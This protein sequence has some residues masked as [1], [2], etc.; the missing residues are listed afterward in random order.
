MPFVHYLSFDDVRSQ[1]RVTIDPALDQ[2]L[3]CMDVFDPEHVQM[4]TLGERPPDPNGELPFG[5]RGCVIGK[6][7]ESD[8]FTLDIFDPEQNTE[9]SLIDEDRIGTESALRERGQATQVPGSALVAPNWAKE[10]VRQFF[11]DGRLL[12]GTLWSVRRIW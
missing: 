7:Y 8:Y 5:G 3:H 6:A 2:I 9:Y 1:D 10:V 11:E 4:I 12:E